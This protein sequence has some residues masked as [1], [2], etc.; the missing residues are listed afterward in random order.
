MKKNYKKILFFIAILFLFAIQF[1]DAQLSGVYTINSGAPTAGTNFQY[2]SDLA[3]ALTSSGVTGPVTVNVVPASG[4][5]NEQPLFTSYT[6]S[7]ASNKVTING[8]GNLLTF[9][10]SNSSQRWTLGLNGA[11]YLNFNNL[12]VEGTGSYAYACLLYSG[13]DN[14]VFSSCTFSV[15]AN[16][17]SSNHTPFAISA[18]A[19]FLS[20]G[21]NSGS[22]N[23]VS[24][25][26]MYSGYY[27]V[28]IAGITSS[29]YQ[30][31]N[32]V[33]N[34]NIEDFYYMGIYFYYQ[35]NGTLKGNVIERPNRTS[36]SFGMYGVYAYNNQ[37]LMLDG[38]R[39]QRVFDSNQT[40]TGTFYGFYVP[41]NSAPGSANRNTYRNN[42]IGDIKH[43]GS[44]YGLYCINADA[45][46][47]NNTLSFDHTL[48]T[49]G[50][51]YALY[52]YCSSSSY[53]NYIYNNIVSITKGG[54][55]TK[56]GIYFAISGNVSSDRN[57][58]YVNSAGGTNYTGYYTGPATN[59]TQLQTQGIEATSF[60][61]DPV[62]TNLATG[63][64]H[65]TSF[66][67]DNQGIVNNLIFDQEGGVRNQSSPDIGALEFLTPACIG[68]PT[69]NAITSPTYA[70]CPGEITTLGLA[71]LNPASGFGYQWQ[72][73]TISQVGPFTPISGATS[74]FYTIPPVSVNTWY[75]IVMT[76][77]N[78]GGGSI[79]PVGQVLVAGNTTTTVPYYE[80]FEG[81]GANNRLPNCSWS[82]SDLGGACQTYTASG[83]GNRTPNSGVSFATFNNFS[84]G[85]NYYY[86]NSIQI[87]TGITYSAAI[88]WATEYFG[89]TNWTD[90]TLMVGPNQS[91][92]GMVPVAS[93]GPA[94][95]GA[96]KLLGNTFTVPS[97]GLYYVAI[98]ATSTAGAAQYLS[99]DDLAITIPCDPTSPNTPTVVLSVNNTTIC[100][101]QPVTLT[102]SG[103]DTYSW[104]TGANG[105][106]ITDMPNGVGTFTYFVI[107]QNALTGCTS[108][109]T[110][111]VNLL[112][113]PITLIYANPA[114]VCFGQPTTLA[115]LGANTYVWS[116]GGT[117]TAIIITPTV[118]TTINV[119][120]TNANGC[121]SSASQTIAILPLPTV[122]ATS[123][124]NTICKDDLVT[125]SASGAVNYKWVSNTLPNLFQGSSLNVSLPSGVTIF[126]VT[127][128]NANGCEG[129]STLSLSVDECTGISKMSGNTTVIQV[130][131]NP[132]ATILN[133]T[134]ETGLIQSVSLIDVTGRVVLTETGNSNKVTL[135][136]SSVSKGVYFAKVV[137]NGLPTLVKLVKE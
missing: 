57:D 52:P 70:L 79:S 93:V 1:I 25:C 105:S 54:T 40:F 137:V 62:F 8:N 102:A 16:T 121:S 74:L 65:P 44:I 33:I 55:G 73:S 60:S 104:S 120:G 5:Y 76:C 28:Y 90:L 112:P 126:T 45:D 61:V 13:A 59:L 42:I 49:G 75:S 109:V 35:K 15:P 27:G 99:I 124:Q 67:I 14:N 123:S 51:V 91:P 100:S 130:Y 38:N 39:I 129:K 117:S 118:N 84:P 30:N 58:L 26:S 24:E 77:T 50:S 94:V 37:G 53:Q 34:C 127:G 81:I 82:S 21:S 95:S 128:T 20:T 111:L 110:Q 43:N 23:L 72:A 48:S 3:S 108:T 101:G 56:Y 97:T 125:L 116:N 7:S 103:A 19:T 10:S 85:V 68:T 9:N 133:I 115:A 86:S 98:R 106:G 47:Y 41:Y 83:T 46:V 96:Y 114:T 12:N 71:S 11:D 113:A 131:P 136:L 88:M 2:F 132:A 78:P 22:N 69:A 29:P 134:S 32:S 66:T 87:T 17:T 107:G 6:G 135:D 89:S 122:L 64:L 119:I 36:S 31:G 63:D 92:T 80:N 18:S 4:P